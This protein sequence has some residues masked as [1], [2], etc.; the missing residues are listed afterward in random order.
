MALMTMIVHLLKVGEEMIRTTTTTETVTTAMMIS[1]T[2]IGSVPILNDKIIDEDDHNNSNEDVGK[3]IVDAML[4]QDGKTAPVLKTKL[5]TRML[6]S[7][8]KN[9]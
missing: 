5:P 1:M 2:A 6:I 7:F 4:V 9:R 3:T 8:P